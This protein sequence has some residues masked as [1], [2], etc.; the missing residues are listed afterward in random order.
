MADREVTV[1]TQIGKVLLNGNKFAIGHLL[2][3]YE[4][5][6]T[7]KRDYHGDAHSAVRAL[8]GLDRDGTYGINVIAHEVYDDSKGGDCDEPV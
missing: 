2:E 5:G 6:R 1:D 3:C 4:I 8:K 7:V